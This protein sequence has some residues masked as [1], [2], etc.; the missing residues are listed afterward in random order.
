MPVN[1]QREV[2]ERLA[3]S[4]AHDWEQRGHRT[5]VCGWAGQGGW[6]SGTPVY[7]AEIFRVAGS[8]RGPLSRQSPRARIYKTLEKCKQRKSPI[9]ASPDSAVQISDSVSSRVTFPPRTKSS[10]VIVVQYLIIISNINTGLSKCGG[11][12]GES[13]YNVLEGIL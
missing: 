3:S 8:R 4:A 13:R 10:T 7:P 6:N 9:F 2:A 11:E 1:I 5:A 12:P